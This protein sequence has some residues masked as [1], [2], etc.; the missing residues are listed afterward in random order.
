MKEFNYPVGSA[1]NAYVSGL[2]KSKKIKVYHDFT[3][4]C[5]MFGRGLPNATTGRKGVIVMDSTER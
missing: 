3:Y 5:L 1:S 2:E 4:C